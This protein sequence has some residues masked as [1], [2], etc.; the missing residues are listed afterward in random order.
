MGI[1]FFNFILQTKQD[2]KIAPIFRADLNSD[3]KKFMDKCISKCEENIDLLYLNLLKT[4]KHKPSKSEAT[5]PV[6]VEGDSD[7]IIIGMYF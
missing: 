4:K 7:V 3:R 5:W 6:H 1:Y 2:M